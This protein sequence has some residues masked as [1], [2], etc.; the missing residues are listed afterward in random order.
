MNCRAP[1]VLA[2]QYNRFVVNDKLFRTIAHDVRKRSQNN[3]VCVMTVDEEM[4]YMK[5]T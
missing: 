1:I 5:L 4:Y 3:N 2:V